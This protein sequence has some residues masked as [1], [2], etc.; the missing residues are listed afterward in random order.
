MACTLLNTRIMKTDT[1]SANENRDPITGE[2]G[3][4][5]IGTGVGSLAGAA[6]G[7][8]LG[9]LGG[10][11]GMAIGGVV[12]AVAGAATGHGLAEELDPTVEDAHWETN[13]R[14]QP[15]YLAG[16]DFGDYGPAY[17]VGYEGHARNR[18]RSFEE[19]EQELASGWE[20]TRGMSR[21]QW[22]HARPAVRDGWHRRDCATPGTTDRTGR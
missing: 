19:S 21:L 22:E 8:F 5:P 20:E 11:V 7:A 14:F 12:G 18:G 16:Y 4:H 1:E 13:Y 17:R 9:A 6:T 2:P 3:S 15:Y 10:P